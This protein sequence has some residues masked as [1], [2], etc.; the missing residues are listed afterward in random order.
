MSKRHIIKDQA[1]VD[2]LV[3][4]LSDHGDVH[5]T[6]LGRF[7]VVSVKG[8][9]V[10]SSRER[11][12]VPVPEFKMVCFTPSKGLRDMLNQRPR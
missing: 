4:E 1:F 10:Y 6:H 8:R 3:G 11:K 12:M 9:K 2:K 7:R 5:I